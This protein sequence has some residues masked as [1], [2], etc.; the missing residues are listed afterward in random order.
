MFGRN[1]LFCAVSKDGAVI[2]MDV[3][4]G[5]CLHHLQVDAPLL[6]CTLLGEDGGGQCLVAAG[7]DGGVH[8]ID[9]TSG[10]Q[11]WVGWE[12]PM[13]RWQHAGKTGVGC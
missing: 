9:C 5:R 6:S 3:R 12:P 2:M 8:F 11:A 1:G 10:E 4:Q 13:Q 7:A